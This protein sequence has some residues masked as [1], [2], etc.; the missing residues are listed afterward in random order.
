MT[1]VTLNKQNQNSTKADC[2]SDP[3]VK[4]Q[5]FLPQGELLTTVLSMGDCHCLILNNIVVTLINH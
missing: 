3:L 5:S 4:S 2:F 1:V